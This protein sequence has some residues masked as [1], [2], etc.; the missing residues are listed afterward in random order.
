MTRMERQVYVIMPAFQP[1][2]GLAERVRELGQEIRVR[3]LVIDDGSGP[4]YEEIFCGSRNHR[5]LSGSSP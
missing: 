3:I 1:E 2:A 5:R 4:E